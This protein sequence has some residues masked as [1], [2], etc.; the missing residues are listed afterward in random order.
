MDCKCTKSS[1]DIYCSQHG[2]EDKKVVT[3]VDKKITKPDTSDK[4]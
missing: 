3:K 4:V 2:D 1:R